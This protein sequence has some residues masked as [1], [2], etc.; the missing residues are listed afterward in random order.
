MSEV[1]VTLI[2]NY[3]YDDK[4]NGNWCCS[5]NAKIMNVTE[6]TST[7]ILCSLCIKNNHIIIK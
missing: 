2:S 4:N 1:K 7:I 5:C 6:T 3:Y